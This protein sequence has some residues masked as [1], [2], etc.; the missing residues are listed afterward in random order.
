MPTPSTPAQP[1]QKEPLITPEADRALIKIMV[2]YGGTF[3]VLFML[4]PLAIAFAN[5][6]GN[7]LFPIHRSLDTASTL[8]IMLPF[9]LGI[10]AMNNARLKF[11]RRYASEE[12]WKGVYGAAESFAQLG[13]NWMDRT[14]EAHYWLAIAQE[15]L[16]QK[17][18]AEKS[19]KFVTKYR[20][21]GEWALKLREIEA[22]RAPRKIS[23][24][25]ASKGDARGKLLKAK[26]RF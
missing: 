16:G 25:K 8:V 19:R 24:I 3:V 20:A 2:A 10:N 21:S 4:A 15:R 14:G 12:N 13:Q 18:E 5:E 23:E 6:K 7:P 22:G 11:A 1:Q 17:A 9:F 26:R